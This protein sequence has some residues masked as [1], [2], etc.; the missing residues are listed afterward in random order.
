[1]RSESIDEWNDN[2]ESKSDNADTESVKGNGGM[3]PWETPLPEGYIDEKIQ[4]DRKKLEC[5]ITGINSSFEELPS[6][7]EFFTKVENATSTQISWPSRLKIGAKTKKDPFVKIIGRPESVAKAKESISNLLRVKKDRITL[8][9]EIGH[10]SHSHIIGRGGRNTQDVMRET[11]CH[12]HF[13]D[14]NKHNDIEKNNQVSIAGGIG[15]VERARSKLRLIS[16]INLNISLELNQKSSINLMDLQRSLTSS[17]ISVQISMISASTIQMIIKGSI[18]YEELILTTIEQFHHYLSGL[19]FSTEASICR[20]SFDLRPALLQSNYGLFGLNTIR[21]IAFHTKTQMQFSPQGSSIL[22]MGSAISIFAARRYLTGLLPVSIQF[23]KPNEATSKQNLRNFETKFD[24]SIGE[25]KKANGSSSE[26]ELCSGRDPRDAFIA[27][28]RGV[29]NSDF[30]KA[31]GLERQIAFNRDKMLLKANKA[32][33][34][35]EISEIRQPT[36]LWAG[37]G[38][39]NSLPADILKLGIKQIWEQ[40]EREKGF[41]ATASINKETK[42]MTPRGL[43]P[44]QQ[45]SQ[46]QA[47]KGLASVREEEELSDYNQSIN[48]NFSS[49]SQT[50]KEFPIQQKRPAF[51]ASASVFESSPTLH[52]DINWDIQIF[53]EPAMVLAQLGCSEYLPQ[54]RDQEIDMQAF[55][56]L[57]EQNLKDIGVST[58]GARKK[59]FNAI[60]KLRDSARKRGY[61]I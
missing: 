37:Y 48:S 55:L 51:A 50:T 52:N 17:E 8:K 35:Q 61:S 34:G 28:G 10:T 13:P 7:S 31:P 1:M 15:Q 40:P 19:G 45:M 49:P 58:M 47:A 12:I 21:W 9:M 26:V 38:F 54:F 3:T 27:D 6:A 33:Y 5:M 57:D 23:E 39:S 16:P 30:W 24:V 14:S 56:L 41:A 53:V 4:V 20:S 22:V 29:N 25:K 60:L 59:I 42:T 11:N 43:L 18:Q 2:S 46:S 36:D 32:T 44:E